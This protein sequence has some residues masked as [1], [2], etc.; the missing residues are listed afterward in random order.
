M[1]GSS[2]LSIAAA[3]ALKRRAVPRC[4]SYLSTGPSV[5]RLPS[6]ASVVASSS[7]SN[8]GSGSNS[9]PS[10]SSASSSSNNNSNGSSSS[11]SNGNGSSPSTATAQEAKADL[12]TAPNRGKSTS[13]GHHHAAAAGASAS[14]KQGV[15]SANPPPSSL[16]SI[17][18]EAFFSNGRPLL[19]HE[20]LPPRPKHP[21]ASLFASSTS[22]SK[23]G[24]GSST[25]AGSL[26]AFFTGDGALAAFGSMN[27][28][29]S[30]SQWRRRIR[31]ISPDRFSKL[32]DGL[33]GLE[34][35]GTKDASAADAAAEGEAATS[36]PRWLISSFIPQSD[37]VALESAK[38]EEEE[39]LKE[40]EEEAVQS[41][42]ER[43]ED[44]DVARKLGIEA[45]LIILGEPNG[46]SPDWS[47]GVATYLAEKGRA[48]EAPP[49]P[50]A[51]RKDAGTV[52]GDDASSTS[53]A[54][55]SEQEI[56]EAIEDAA[57][58][59]P[60]AAS[61]AFYTDDDPNLILSHALVQVTLPLA[62]KW[63]R[64]VSQM[65]A[66]ALDRPEKALEGIDLTKLDARIP[67]V[68][69]PHAERDAYDV[70]MD[71]VRRKRRKK[72][73]KHKYKKLRKEQRAERQRM[74]K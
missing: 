10:S 11:G 72:I 6:A 67:R 70:Q 51:R 55:L 24:S 34:G 43:G 9:S 4:R 74:K 36:E 44:P 42:L 56:Q 22:T 19:Q 23:P 71:S 37:R 32:V 69:A 20:M 65:D 3:S 2:S 12:A 52:G 58:R 62:L 31:T 68:K 40:E 47:R 28:F 15:A 27:P 46:P 8:S 1:T 26:T 29:E 73:R 17:A 60:H 49:A 41:A 66:V 33:A 53:P 48:Y 30:Q 38:L 13:G 50:Q 21:A 61:T 25:G 39:R 63:D 64:L 18:Y 16:A 57:S 5:S 45:D 14:A 7:D 59:M 54:A 35:Q